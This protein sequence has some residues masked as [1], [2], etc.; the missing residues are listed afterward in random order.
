MRRGVSSVLSR[1]LAEAKEAQ[2]QQDE[3]RAQAQQAHAEPTER[4]QI[5][6]LDRPIPAR[7]EL[8]S[9]DARLELQRVG[10]STFTLLGALP[11]AGPFEGF[12][13][14]KVEGNFV[15]VG[16][17]KGMHTD[18]VCAAIRAALPSGIEATMEGTASEVIVLTFWRQQNSGADPEVTFASTDPRQVL[19][20]VRGNK[21]TISGR[22]AR[23]L[24]MRAWVELSVEGRAPRVPLNSGDEPLRTA[25]RLRDAM[26][27][28]FTALIELPSLPGGEVSVTVLRT[29]RA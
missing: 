6:V 22:A 16:L 13:A 18:D 25:E 3:A 1:L 19:R 27:G 28:G 17:H 14:L 23:S 5:E 20:W 9:A 24:S 4:L 15:T 11:D 29:R 21:F 7:V 2:A 8:V 10:P 26:P 12:I